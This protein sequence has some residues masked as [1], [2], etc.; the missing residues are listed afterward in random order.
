VGK[1]VTLPYCK[2][3]HH[4]FD[5][6]WQDFYPRFSPTPRFSM[7]AIALT[8]L[9]RLLARA[10]PTRR[11]PIE[12]KRADTAGDRTRWRV[13]DRIR[14]TDGARIRMHRLFFVRREPFSGTSRESGGDRGDRVE[15]TRIAGSNRRTIQIGGLQELGRGRKPRMDR[16][17]DGE[18][19]GRKETLS[20]SSLV[21]VNRRRRAI[22]R[23]I[24]VTSPRA[25]RSRFSANGGSLFHFDREADLATIP[26]EL[27]DLNVC[28]MPL[29]DPFD[30][31]RNLIRRVVVAQFHRQ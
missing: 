15:S 16:S 6:S 7:T 28:R 12:Q 25:G 24:L 18:T 23:L 21:D 11:P 3:K 1:K 17:A 30:P 13:A 22:R 19:R 26:R 9:A 4:Q 10:K 20:A 29:L 14:R 2:G 27:A 31:F 5:F 8:L